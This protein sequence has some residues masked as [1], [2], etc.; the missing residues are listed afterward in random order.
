MAGISHSTQPSALAGSTSV[1]RA[2]ALFQPLA[3]VLARIRVLAS[4]LVPVSPVGVRGP[5]S[6]GHQ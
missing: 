3:A 2:V 5:Y 4:Q 6:L 1:E